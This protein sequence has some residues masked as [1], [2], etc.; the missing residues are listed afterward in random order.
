MFL[1]APFIFRIGSVQQTLDFER[2][3]DWMQELPN[4]GGVV[5]CTFLQPPN[6]ENNFNLPEQKLSSTIQMSSLKG[7][8]EYWPLRLPPG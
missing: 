8:C 6:T 3:E 1:N 2:A 4:W 5:C 7:F